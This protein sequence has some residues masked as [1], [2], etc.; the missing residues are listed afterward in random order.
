L[1]Q[2]CQKRAWKKH[3]KAECTTIAQIPE[4]EAILR[5][6]IRMFV[7]HQAGNVELQKDWPAMMALQ[8]DNLQK[9]TA[10]RVPEFC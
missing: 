5:L 2:I 10:N 1:R 6:S 3:H 8:S 7:N 9:I 4:R